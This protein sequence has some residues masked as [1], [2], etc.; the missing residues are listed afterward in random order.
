M[1]IKIHW[2]T[3]HYLEVSCVNFCVVFAGE[4]ER[5]SYIINFFKN[6]N[7]IC[8]K[9]F[10]MASDERKNGDTRCPLIELT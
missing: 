9:S 3:Y 1:E 5:F 6:M 4:T 10:K 8:V 2:T 7:I